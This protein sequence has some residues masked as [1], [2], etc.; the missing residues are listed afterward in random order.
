MPRLLTRA[1]PWL[2][3]AAGAIVL[4]TT[5]PPVGSY[6]RQYAYVQ[7]AQF[8]I[9]AVAAPALL[10]IGLTPRSERQIWRLPDARRAVLIAAATLLPFIALVI[11]WRLPAVLSTLARYPALTAAEM[12]TL[13]CAGSAVWVQLVARSQLPR[14]MRAAMAAVAMWS[15]WAVAY[16]TGMSGSASAWKGLTPTALS[17][18]DDRQMAVGVMWA[19]PAI[20]FTP[21]AYVMLMKW[22]GERDDPDAELRSAALAGST[23]TDLDQRPRPPRGWR[24]LP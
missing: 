12:I 3:P 23:F 5:L 21:V 24:A 11:T 18:P 6:A 2:A 14:P 19:V 1:M 17:A 8:V 7:A 4:L 16:I 15:I 13:V 22:L 9:F 20:C 10:V